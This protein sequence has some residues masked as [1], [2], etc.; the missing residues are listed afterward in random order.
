MHLFQFRY[1]AEGSYS[2]GVVGTEDVDCDYVDLT[3]VSH[4]YSLS[5]LP[6]YTHDIYHARLEIVVDD[7]AISYPS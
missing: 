1:K 7:F 6:E 5:S 4:F 2:V 3:Y